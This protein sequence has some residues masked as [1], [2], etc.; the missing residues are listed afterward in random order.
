MHFH[1]TAI[2]CHVTAIACQSASIA[3]ATSVEPFECESVYANCSHITC[4]I[5]TFVVGGIAKLAS[6]IAAML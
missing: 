2:A 3:L 6:S 4:D 5:T 1:V